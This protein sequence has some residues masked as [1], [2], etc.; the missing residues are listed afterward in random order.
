MLGALKRSSSVS[1]A[2]RYEVKSWS[3]EQTLYVLA[4]FLRC[5]I[6]ISNESNEKETYIGKV[7]FSHLTSNIRLQLVVE[8]SPHLTE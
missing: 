5:I 6:I 7:N 3:M 1:V 4:K 8:K 2:G